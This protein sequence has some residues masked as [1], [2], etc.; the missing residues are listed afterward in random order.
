M[1]GAVLMGK[2]LTTKGGVNLLHLGGILYGT[3]SGMGVE[4]IL[5]I[6]GDVCPPFGERK[7][8]FG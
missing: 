3:P 6:L 2:C 7:I 5:D 1:V 8:G 4:G